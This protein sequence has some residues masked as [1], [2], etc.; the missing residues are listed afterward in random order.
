MLQGRIIEGVSGSG[1]TRLL[2]E[3]QVQL[4]RQKPGSTRLVLSEHYTERVLE[5]DRHPGRLSF[6]DVLRHTSRIVEQV[7]ALA[8]LKRDSIYENRR[9]NA[10]VQVLIE[11]FVGSHAANLALSGGSAVALATEEAGEARRQ[12]ERLGA[13]GVVPM[14]LEVT[15]D[16]LQAS[17]RSTR[18]HRNVEWTRFLDALGTDVEATQ[19]FLLWQEHLL[20]FYEIIGLPYQ[21]LTVPAHDDDAAWEA[22]GLRLA[23][24]LLG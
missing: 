24:E 21:R 13:R 4:A 1:K 11:R 23:A 7:E 3:I 6:M 18:Q 5:E 16:R 8:E 10:G 17:L 19:R 20:A 22:L 9:G 15:R 2:G 12:F 14:V